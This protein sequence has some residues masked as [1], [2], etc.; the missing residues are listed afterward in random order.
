[1]AQT[2]T[3]AQR[4]LRARMGAHRQHALYDPRETTAKARA[5]FLAGFEREVDPDSILPPSERMRRADQARRAYFT[6]LALKSS[7]ARDRSSP[8]RPHWPL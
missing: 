3:P 2:L 7:I 4:K 8:A 5:S 6:A 1:M